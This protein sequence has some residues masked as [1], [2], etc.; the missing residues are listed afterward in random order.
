[1][2]QW[3]SFKCSRCN[4]PFA[5][6]ASTAMHITQVHKGVGVAEKRARKFI[7][8]RDDESIASRMIKAELDRACGVFNHDEWLLP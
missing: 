8:E 5:S 6:T 7:E 4:K 1:M 2:S 3:K